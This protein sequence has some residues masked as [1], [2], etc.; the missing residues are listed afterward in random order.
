[1]K[2]YG[3]KFFIFLFLVTTQL[4]ARSGPEETSEYHSKPLVVGKHSMIIT[5]NKWATEAAQTMLNKGGNAFGAAIAAGFVLG[6]T[7]PQSSG[8]GGGGHALTFS[9]KNHQLL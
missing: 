6:L 9:K 5:N 3:V 8:V 4:Y 7:H 1:M 2:T